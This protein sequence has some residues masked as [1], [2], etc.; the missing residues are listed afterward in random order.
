MNIVT[1]TKNDVNK[2]AQTF[3]ASYNLP[4]WNYKWKLPDA[5]K[6]LAEYVDCPQF[7]GYMICDDDKVCGALLGHTKTWWT[8][9][10]FMVDELFI[11]SDKQGAGYGKMLLKQAEVY[12]AANNI[13]MITLMTNKFMPALKFYTKNDFATFPQFA[14]LFKCL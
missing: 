14:F 8:S 6:Y 4:P 3:I 2:C 12:A 5:E 10:Q 9:N 13:G 1:L 7:V 11:S